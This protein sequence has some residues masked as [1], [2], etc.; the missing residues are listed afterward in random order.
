MLKQEILTILEQL[1]QLHL[2]E[3]LETL[4]LDQQAAFL[5]QLKTL[6]PS[7]LQ[8][9]RLLLHTQPV[10][11]PWE[12]WKEFAEPTPSFFQEGQQKISSGKTACLILA[13]GQG[14]R[15]G[16]SEPKALFPVTAVHRKTLLQLLC[17]KIATAS[18]TYNTPLQIALMV[19][20]LNYAAI[21][22]Y[23]HK[24]GY[25]GLS[26]S[27]VHLFVQETAPF[28]SDNESWFLEAPG[29]IA[30][31]PDGNGHSLKKLADSRIA[32]KWKDQGI[33][34]VNI[35][36]I[37]NPLADPFDPALF[38]YHSLKAHAIT[39]KAILRSDPAEKVGLIV[40][41]NGRLAVQEYS[42][43]SFLNNAPLAYIGLLCLNLS[44]I[45]HIASLEFPWHL[46]R[47]E[48]AEQPIWKYEH[49][50]FDALHFTD[51]SGVLVFPRKDV[52]AP[53]KNLSDLP[54]VQRAVYSLE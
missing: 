10:V 44:F 34:M 19:S 39:L 54:N 20:P 23:L 7:L 13:G 45:E 6:T 32:Q 40:R 50:L 37:D 31:G 36:P 51:R 47:K 8:Q 5:N 52:F 14:S 27:Q 38:G 24:N 30:A 25:F 48:H 33:E 15:L 49:F 16:S 17:E 3:G 18:H 26:L 29:K 35:L 12:P 2:A 28:L 46:A 11:E 43:V 4:S 41:K 53:L 22:Q 9:Q 1:G 21:H 42:E